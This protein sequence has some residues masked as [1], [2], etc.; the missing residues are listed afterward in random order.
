MSGRYLTHSMLKCY[1]YGLNIMYLII[2]LIIMTL[3]VYFKVNP[4]LTSWSIN[5][6]IIS[7]GV[8][9]M[10]VAVAGLYGAWR[11]H[12]IILFFYMVILVILFILLFAFS[13][14]A[15]AITKAQQR[16][17]LQTGWANSHMSTKV[18]IQKLGN[19]CGF[20]NKTI[21]AGKLGHPSC[22]KLKCCNGS[23]DVTCP[24]CPTCLEQLQTGH[25]KK[26][27]KVTGGVALFFSFSMFLGVYFA[28]KYRHMRN[29]GANPNAFM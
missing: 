2:A 22:L 27:R 1:L 28:F 26:F 5:G 21:T 3:P 18:N 12:Q 20:E 19:C 29:P 14:G 6:G 17:V 15:L 16:L 10:L 11:Q 13:L 4:L 9:L 8:F 25:F 24:K 23:S 7:A